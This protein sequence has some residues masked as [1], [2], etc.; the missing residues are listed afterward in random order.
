MVLYLR[1]GYDLD[2][3]SLINGTLV[4]DE[5]EAL[6]HFNVEVSCRLP[7]VS[8]TVYVRNL[9]TVCTLTLPS[10]KDSVDCIITV[11]YISDMSLG[12]TGPNCRVVYS[13]ADANQVSYTLNDT[14]H[15]V[16]LW[17]NGLQW[18]LIAGS[19]A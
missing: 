10:V 5:S 14:A 2:M 1:G 3:T 18:Y 12:A 7:A 6:Q 8:C 16:A 15:Y 19:T 13:K 4:P 11:R 17:C 9:N